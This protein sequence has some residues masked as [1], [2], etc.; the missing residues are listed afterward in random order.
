MRAHGELDRLEELLRMNDLILNAAVDDRHLHPK[1]YRACKKEIA[2]ERRAYIPPAM[3]RTDYRYFMVSH[4]RWW[5]LQRISRH[6][7]SE[8]PPLYSADAGASGSGGG[9]DVERFREEAEIRRELEDKPWAREGIVIPPLFIVKE[10]RR[11]Q[12]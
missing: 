7:R 5:E 9:A 10:N 6:R 3:G 2:A 12:T 4:R 1:I 11:G 8:F